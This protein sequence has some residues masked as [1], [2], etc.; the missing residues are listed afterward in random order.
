MKLEYILSDGRFG[1]Q[2]KYQCI[3]W[4][5]FMTPSHSALGEIHMVYFGAKSTCSPPV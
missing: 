5:E 3:L 2:I 4:V 1:L